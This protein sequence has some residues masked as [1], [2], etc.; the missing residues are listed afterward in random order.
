VLADEGEPTALS[1]FVGNAVMHG[2]PC[3]WHDDADPAV[4]P[5]SSPWV[6]NYG[7]YYN[8]CVL[9]TQEGSTGCYSDLFFPL[10]LNNLSH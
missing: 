9:F 5:P 2:D 8:R 1:S 6:H 7:Y 4:L 3:A 10:D